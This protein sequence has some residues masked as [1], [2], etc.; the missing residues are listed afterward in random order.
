MMGCLAEANRR[1]TRQFL[2]SAKFM[3][4]YP[5]G[6]VD[7]LAVAFVASNDDLVTRKGFLGQALH[8]T[9]GKGTTGATGSIREV[10][11]QFAT[12]G[13]SDHAASPASRGNRA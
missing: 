10:V 9:H 1:L 13:F 7:R 6:R 4:L 8:L 11:N 3:T 2:R 12:P 5:D